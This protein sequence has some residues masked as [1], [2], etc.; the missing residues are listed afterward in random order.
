MTEK[1]YTVSSKLTP[2]EVAEILQ[3]SVRKVKELDIPYYKIDSYRRYDL[4]DVETYIKSKKV[5]PKWI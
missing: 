2:E 1:V 5:Y 3:L 4:K